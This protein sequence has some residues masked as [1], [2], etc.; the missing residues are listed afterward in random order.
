MVARSNSLATASAKRSR[1]NAAG[2][3]LALVALVLFAVVILWGQGRLAWC[4]CGRPS[5]WTGDVW[6]SHNSQ[7][8]VDPYSFSHAQHGILLYGLLVWLCPNVRIGWRLFFAAVIE[9]AWEVAENSE[10]MIERY[11]TATISLEYFG[12]TIGNS[13]GDIASFLVGFWLAS[14]LPI[15]LSVTLLVV[16]ELVMVIAMRDSLS[17]NT[18]MLVYPIEAVKEWQTP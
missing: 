5:L 11:R 14:R 1:L 17:L 7:H 12:D 3:W 10:F 8:L 15:W 18:L 16:T 4:E 6:S 9:V 13:L 2:P